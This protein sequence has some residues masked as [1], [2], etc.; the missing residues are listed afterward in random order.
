M[1]KK[2]FS[3]MMML[4]VAAASLTACDKDDDPTPGPGNGDGSVEGGKYV[5]ATTVQGSNG[6]AYVILT[7]ESLDEGTL[8]T[9]GNGIT[10]DAATQWVFYKNYLYGLQYNQ[11]NSGGT[12]RYYMLP[13]GEMYKSDESYN[14]DRFSSY[15]FYGDDIIT[16]ATA[17]GP[18]KYADAKGNRQMVLTVDWLNVLAGSKTT[19][20][21]EIAEGKYSLENYVG[22]GEY[23]T[24]SGAEQSGTKLYSGVIPMG[25]SAYGVAYDNGKWVKYPDLI[26]QESGGSGGGAYEAN[27]I[28]GTQYP[29]E[30]WVAIYNN[31][32][33]L[34]PTLAYTDQISYP[35]GRFRSQYYQTIWADDNGDIYVF[36]SSYSKTSTDT[37]QQTT[38][39]AGVCRIPKNSTK[40]DDYYCNIE[41]QTPGGNRTF[42]RC[43]PA[44]GSTF[45][46][47]M[48]NGPISGVGATTT[49]T[50]LAIFNAETKKLTYVTGLPDNVSSV[51][52]T[53]FVENGKVYIPINVGEESSSTG[54]SGHG[55]GGRASDVSY[56]AL[57]GIDTN[58][59]VATKGVTVECTSI[60]G[61][62]YLTPAE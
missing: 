20:A 52:K 34:N 62:G 1:N 35:C 53:V 49:A 4:A 56:P 30:C 17:S 18:E 16:T 54:G 48:Y 28:S 44:G 10:S 25:L 11:G 26:K 14:I 47:L 12:R 33:M 50:D 55:G 37:R 3:R 40:F 51:G 19:N 7:G 6:S 39:D 61:F 9:V 15:G 2:L 60:N 21:D 36:S 29:N 23:V 24:L 31:G 57:Y 13:N 38:L 59:A 42:M 45:L 22:N 27:T 43:W 5:F 32:D 41:K 58:T 46:M 8:T